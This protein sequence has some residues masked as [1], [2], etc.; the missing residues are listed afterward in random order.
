MSKTVYCISCLVVCKIVFCSEF[1]NIPD[2]AGRKTRRR[3]RR[4]QVI[5]KRYALHA[6]TKREKE[7]E[8]EKI[9]SLN[10]FETWNI[11]EHFKN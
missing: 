5:A 8:K 2:D 10:L 9:F 1:P 11:T 7:K 3:R 6:N 4:T